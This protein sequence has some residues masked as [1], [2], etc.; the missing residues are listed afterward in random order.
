MSRIEEIIA[1]IEEYIDNCKFQPL[2]NSKIIV[3]RDD[4]DEMIAELKAHTPDEI[5]KYQKI[6][7]N[8]N[9]IL[10]E[11]KAK[12]EEMIAHAK[13]QV[14]D[15]ISEH[16]IMQQAYAQANEVVEAATSQAQEILD[17][18]TEDA[19]NIRSASIE[20][21]DNL[22]STVQNIVA[23]TI[24][25]SR[26]YYD[27][28][29]GTLEDTLNTVVHNRNELYGSAPEDSVENLDA[30]EVEGFSVISSDDK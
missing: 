29:F 3:N 9:E 26:T 13:F 12:A 17:Q 7:N 5:R 23:K 6:L 14:N 24:N 10:E 16:E 19:N 8:K 22:L 20:Y 18:A 25:D 21:T 1:E 4:L 15:M 11:A 2:S 27:G 30:A 28:L